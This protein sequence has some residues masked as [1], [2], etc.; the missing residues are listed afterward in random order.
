MLLTDLINVDDFK[1]AFEDPRRLLDRLER[2]KPILQ[3]LNAAAHDPSFPFSRNRKEIMESWA[4]LL[5]H[6]DLAIELCTTRM[7][8]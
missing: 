3:F 2:M 8:R 1:A 4:F 6:I 7:T 5:A